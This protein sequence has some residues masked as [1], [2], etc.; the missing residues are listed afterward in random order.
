MM[1][2][3]SLADV[4]QGRRTPDPNGGFAYAAMIKDRS[5]PGG[6]TAAVK[7][8]WKLIETATNAELYNLA[9]DPTERNNLIVSRPKVLEDLRTMLREFH[10]NAKLSPFCFAIPVPFSAVSWHCARCCG[11]RSSSSTSHALPPIV[12]TSRSATASSRAG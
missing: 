5:N 3:R 9:R 8:P 2:G 7:G 11:A 4:A 6:V 12:E 1:D 10:A